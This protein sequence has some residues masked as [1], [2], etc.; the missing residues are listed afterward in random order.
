[1]KQVPKELPCDTVRTMIEVVPYRGVVFIR[2]AL[3]DLI[4]R[5]TKQRRQ[6][7]II[8]V[9]LLPTHPANL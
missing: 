8:V 9:K 3:L 6:R 5:G 2:K 7:L 1:M 4:E